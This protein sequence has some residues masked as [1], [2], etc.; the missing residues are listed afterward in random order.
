VLVD[1][2]GLPPEPG[3]PVTVGINLD[4]AALDVRGD[5]VRQQFRA[6]QWLLAIRFTDLSERVQ[7]RLRRRVFQ[8]LREE[9]A[10]ANH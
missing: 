9:R 10:R 7:D 6:V 3:A 2:W 4:G 1:G 5:I 8:S